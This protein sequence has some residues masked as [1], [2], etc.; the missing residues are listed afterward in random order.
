M[1]NSTEAAKISVGTNSD[2]LIATKTVQAPSRIASSDAEEMLRE[3]GC[4]AGRGI[5]DIGT[6]YE[7]E[8]LIDET[9]V[10]QSLLAESS[11]T[12]NDMPDDPQNLR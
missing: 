11:Q 8:K 10:S 5:L 12:Q 2:D 1:P 7:I 9:R 6:S 4:I 3:A